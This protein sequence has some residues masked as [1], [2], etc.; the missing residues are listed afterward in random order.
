MMVPVMYNRLLD[1]PKET[2]GQFDLSSLKTLISGGAPLHTATKMKIKETF[3]AQAL[4]E[5]YGSTEL[6]VS[7]TLRDEDQLKKERSIGKPL[8]DLELTILNPDGS[9]TPQGEVGSAVF[10]GA[11]GIPWVL[12]K[13][14]CHG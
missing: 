8:Q 14:R 13:S 4:N 10:P 1:L 9:P 5:F 3:P 12:E 11:W 7:T 6:G 2:L